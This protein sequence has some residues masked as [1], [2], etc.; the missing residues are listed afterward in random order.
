LGDA[1]IVCSETCALD[2]IGATYVR[3]VE[4]GEVV[5]VS[6]GGVKSF[7]LFAPAPSAQCIFEH[8]Y[9]ARP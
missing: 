4:P 2:L 6:G 7:K 5:I 1:L 9:F 3:D 8:V